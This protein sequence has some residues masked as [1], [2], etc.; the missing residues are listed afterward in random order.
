MDSERFSHM[1]G[2]FAVPALEDIVRSVTKGISWIICA[3][4]C[5]CSIQ[6]IQRRGLSRENTGLG[7]GYENR[8]GL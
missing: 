6:R 2:G 8:L 1:V 7:F 3:E 5:Q 4:H